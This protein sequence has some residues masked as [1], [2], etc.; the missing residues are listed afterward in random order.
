[1]SALD[2]ASTSAADIA[3]IWWVMFW[4]ALAVLAFMIALG[5]F[6][7]LRAPGK[8]VPV[9]SRVFI[10]GGGVLFP[11]VVVLL[12]LGYGLRLGEALLPHPAA[13]DVFRVEVTAHRWW[14]EI[15]YPDAPGGALFDANEIHIPVG[16]QTEIHV[17]GADV[18]H[19]FWVPRLGPKMDAVPGITNVVRIEAERPGVFRGQCSEF[20]GAQHAHMALHV[21][22]HA[23]GAHEERLGA[24]AGRRQ[25]LE[26]AAAHPGFE[27][28]Q[29][30]CARCHGLDPH[31][32][33]PAIGPNLAGLG[34]RRF[35]GAGT[36]GNGPVHRRQWL[37]EHQE[38]KPGNL[39]IPLD[40]IE[41][42][43]IEKI[44]EFLDEA[45]S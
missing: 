10:I 21:E 39:M 9:S 13:A 31:V 17:T 22:A 32:Q 6:V 38:I 18:I 12:L 29:E 15:R 40:A 2:P 28:F 41:D 36:I 19:S 37:R 44:A 11:G 5:V 1:M 14:W 3:D 20:C 16:R 26:A 34:Q 27:P 45:G 35:L 30:V 33:G 8:R 7:S 25:A 24:L 43:T 42:S 23:D 4:G